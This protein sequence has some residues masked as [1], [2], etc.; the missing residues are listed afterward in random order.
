MPQI[1]A[2]HSYRG[3]TGKSNLAAN[4]ATAIALQG[5]RVAIVDTDLQSPGIHILFGLG[6]TLNKSLNDFLW[7]RLPI[8]NTAYD[9]SRAFSLSGTGKL[10]CVPASPDPNE[11]AR[12]LSAGYNISLL[13]EGFRQ[14]IQ[15]LKLDYLFL[16]THPGLSRETLLSIAISHLLLLILRPDQQ[17]L[18]GTAV[19]VEVARQLQVNKMMLVL[20]KVLARSDAPQLQ[21]T[22]ES[23]YNIPVAGIFPLSEEMM[24]V[25]SRGLFYLQY[26]HHPLTEI[27]TQV[28]AKITHPQTRS[29]QTQPQT[30]VSAVR[31]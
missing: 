29:P 30:V 6:Q 13:N 31:R 9:A 8:Q 16:D 11:I 5:K 27:F 12:I 4:L 28:A 14:L 18:Q 2:I 24:A 26:P 21:Q 17:D 7:N 23:D 20:N 22:L 10:F 3:G 15:H 19:T 1:I 25:G